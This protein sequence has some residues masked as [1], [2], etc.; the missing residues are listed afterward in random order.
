MIQNP[1]SKLL[2]IFSK[3]YKNYQLFLGKSIAILRNC[4]IIILN[5]V[6]GFKTNWFVQKE[7]I[8]SKNTKSAIY[9]I[10]YYY[11]LYKIL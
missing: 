6:I 10:I 5:P 8:N 1:N 11:S 9:I 7:W 3:I 2:L 4:T